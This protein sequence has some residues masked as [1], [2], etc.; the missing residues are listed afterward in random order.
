MKLPEDFKEFIELLNAH[1]VKYLIVGGYAVGFHSRPKF[2]HDID[3][4]IENSE[5]NARKVLS[6][7]MDFGFG[8]LDVKISDLTNPDMVIQLGYAP[9]RIDIITDL[10][11][12][13]FSESYSRKVKGNY[14]GVDTYFI[15]I[16]DLIKNKE[17]AGRDKDLLDVKWIKQY[18]SKF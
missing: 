18:S 7:L 6:V 4:W 13:N 1:Q 15:S 11:G 3:F 8:E 12:L 9:L 14:L 5:N 16:N 10:S 2:T 17:M